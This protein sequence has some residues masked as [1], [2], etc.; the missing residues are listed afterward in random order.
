[1]PRVHRI[2]ACL[3]LDRTVVHLLLG[4]AWA[5]HDGMSSNVGLFPSPP[6]PYGTLRDQIVD[7]ETK[8]HAVRT[9]THGM[10]AARDEGRTLL[11]TTLDCM[12]SYVQ[13]LC[14]TSPEHAMTLIATASMKVAGL[15]SRS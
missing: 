15:P 11:V 13:S 6:I 4:R 5:I 2:R 14:D 10:A 8:Q 7:L 9:G 3:A 12:R 1:M